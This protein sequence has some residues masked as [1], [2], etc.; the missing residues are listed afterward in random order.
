MDKTILET[1]Y[2]GESKEDRKESELDDQ[3][4]ENEEEKEQRIHELDGKEYDQLD[5][6]QSIQVKEED[7]KPIFGWPCKPQDEDT[8]NKSLLNSTYVEL[9]PKYQEI[10]KANMNIDNP[11]NPEKAITRINPFS[12]VKK[13]Q[14]GSSNV[15][16]GCLSISIQDQ[17]NDEK[18]SNS[19]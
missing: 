15:G 2:G 4:Y 18:N 14:P 17:V 7:S 3:S 1:T 11:S 9:N 19:N 12:R 8:D 5:D 13:Y 16:S 10:S 6:T